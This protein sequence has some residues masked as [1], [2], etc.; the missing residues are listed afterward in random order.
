MRVQVTAREPVWIRV[1]GDGKYLYSG[2]L[3]PNQTR[4]W[5]AGSVVELFLGNA[6]GADILLNGKPVGPAGPRGQVRT[7]QLTLGGLTIVSPKP[8]ASPEPR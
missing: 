2:N 4:E 5:A 3:E 8:A 7:V 1:R 6:G